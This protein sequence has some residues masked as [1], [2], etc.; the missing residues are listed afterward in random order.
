MSHSFLLS[1]RVR[2]V[3]R[4]VDDAADCRDRFRYKP[5]DESQTRLEQLP[6]RIKPRTNLEQHNI[7]IYLR[8]H[9]RSRSHIL[10][11]IDLTPVCAASCV[12]S[13]DVVVMLSDCFLIL[14]H[15]R[16]LN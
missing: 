15:G 14:G 4:S 12:F 1:L 9:V 10:V 11:I 3:L 8:L 13:H 5:E 6:F 16:C 7:S 2:A